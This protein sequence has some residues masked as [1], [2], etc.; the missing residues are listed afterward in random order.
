MKW[1]IER[2]GELA[3][4][5]R[6]RFSVRPRNDP[7]YYGGTMPFVQ[8][9]DIS[10][11]QNGVIRTY[12]QTLNRKGVSVSK[13]FPKGTLLVSIAANIGDSAILG[14]ESACPDSVIAVTPSAILSTGFLRHYMSAQQRWL[15]YLAP[16]GA[17]KN[18]NIDFIEDLEI[19]HPPLPEQQKIADIL[20]TWD[21]ALEKLDALIA[22]KARRKQALMQQLLTGRIRVKAA[23]S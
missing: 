19:E 16:S 7:A 1:K 8:T 15:T 5:E 23:S 11:A 18:I 3:R 22:A 13:V 17:Q 21:E 2:L 12:S 9:G 6:G 20:G 4:V 14:F 10:G